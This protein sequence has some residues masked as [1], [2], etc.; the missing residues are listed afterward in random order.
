MNPTYDVINDYLEEEAE[1]SHSKMTLFSADA[2]FK[3]NFR[4]EKRKRDAS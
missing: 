4:M 1:E 3:K 2:L